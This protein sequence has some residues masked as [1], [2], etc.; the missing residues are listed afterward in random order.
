MFLVC[1]LAC[2]V[3]VGWALRIE[4]SEVLRTEG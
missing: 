2:I 3:P 4:P 1:V